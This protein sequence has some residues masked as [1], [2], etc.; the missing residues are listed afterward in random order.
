M[1]LI[2]GYNLIF[3]CGLQGRQTT[4]QSLARARGVLLG[5]IAKSIPAA[6][7]SQVTVV[8]DARKLPFSGQQEQEFFGKIK[9]LYS[10]NYP[11]AD[12]LIEELIAKHSVPKKLTV[13]SSDHR[14]HK[15]AL[16]RNANPIDSGD[17]YDQLVAG[18]WSRNQTAG[19]TDQSSD[20][21]KPSEDVFSQQELDRFRQDMSEQS[22][23]DPAHRDRFRRQN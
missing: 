9:V 1:F 10:I 11:E 4:S 2:D 12:E 20:G 3:E 16:R 7:H 17:W 19:Q 5:T 15:A 22:P 23:P 8:F 6:N 13:V 18:E 14:L 21:E